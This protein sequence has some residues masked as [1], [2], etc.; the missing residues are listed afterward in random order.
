MM[1][2]C[3]VSDARMTLTGSEEHAGRWMTRDGLPLMTTLGLVGGDA[4]TY[5][6]DRGAMRLE[7]LSQRLDWPQWMTL[8]GVGALVRQGLVRA[9]QRGSD[10]MLRTRE[11]AQDARRS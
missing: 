6:E 7:E 5:L 1:E 4:L 3:E 11:T 8:M 2:T 10:V 9:T